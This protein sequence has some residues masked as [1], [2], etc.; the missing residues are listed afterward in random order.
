MSLKFRWRKFSRPY[1]DL[2]NFST[3]K[4][5]GY[6]QYKPCLPALSPPFK[7]RGDEAVS[8]KIY[9]S[10]LWLH[11]AWLLLK[12]PCMLLLTE[13]QGV[14]LCEKQPPL[15]PCGSN[16]HKCQSE[17]HFVSICGTLC[18][19]SAR[20][21]LACGQREQATL[22]ISVCLSTHLG[23]PIATCASHKI[24][25]TSWYQFYS[26]H[27][28]CNGQQLRVHDGVIMLILHE[29]MN[30]IRDLRVLFFEL[31]E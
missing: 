22:S 10:L 27:V 11:E 4:I 8:I 9:A 2:R 18:A 21:Q 30:T 16:W 17:G 26:L 3:S 7:G 14:P 6:I 25:S 28:L 23:F 31:C 1:S 24:L 19:P 5:L 12:Y 13:A 20:F 29:S 15:Q